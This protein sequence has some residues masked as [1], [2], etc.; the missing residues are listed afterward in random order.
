MA[1]VLTIP[2][3]I[4]YKS[5]AVS[6]SKGNLLVF[7]DGK[8]NATRI[9]RWSSEAGWTITTPEVLPTLWHLWI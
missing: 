4:G 3:D 1:N 6:D 5:K 2:H 7:T 8:A 9:A